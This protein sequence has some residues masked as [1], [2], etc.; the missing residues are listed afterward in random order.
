MK[1]TSV[2]TTT[3]IDKKVQEI[4]DLDRDLDP[5]SAG[6]P[7]KPHNIMQAAMVH[8]LDNILAGLR[9]ET[10]ARK[11][12]QK[13]P[14]GLPFPMPGN[15]MEHAANLHALGK[16]AAGTPPPPGKAGEVL[17]EWLKTHDR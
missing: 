7:R 13:Q 17:A 16:V 1:I 12:R 3:E 2:R 5:I 9:A 8:G 15:M 4:I 6:R 11:T 10:E 14:S